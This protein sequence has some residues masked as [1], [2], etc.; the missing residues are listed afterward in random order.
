VDD[1]VSAELAQREHLILPWRKAFAA[2]LVLHLAAAVGLVIG[3]HGHG[4]PLTLP[5]VQVRIGG[6]LPVAPAPS[7]SEAGR[8]VRPVQAAKP[9]AQAAPVAQPPKHPLPAT[10]PTAKP[11]QAAA[12][13]PVLASGPIT[14]QAQP[15]PTTGQTGNDQPGA[16]SGTGLRSAGGG[17]GIGAGTNGN[18]SGTDE[19]FP[20]SYYLTRVLGLIESNWFKPPVGPGARCRVRCVIDR[21]GRLLEAGIEEESGNPAFDRAALRAVYATAPLPPLPQGFVGGSLTLHLEFGP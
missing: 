18:S 11:V 14:R 17:L 8:G 12:R 9:A 7:P 16:A 19:T 15:A 2:A 10:K 4:R 21:S 3:G 13:G 6:L 5:R 20:F 1:P